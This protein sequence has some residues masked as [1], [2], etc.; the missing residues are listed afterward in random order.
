MKCNAKIRSDRMRVI[1]G[2]IKCRKCGRRALRL[3]AKESRGQKK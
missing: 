2:K 3:K 1:R